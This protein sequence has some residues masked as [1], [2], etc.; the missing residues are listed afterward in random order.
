MKTEQE[1][2]ALVREAIARHGR[3]AQ[4]PHH[5]LISCLREV[6]VPLADGHEPIRRLQAN[7]LIGDGGKPRDSGSRSDRKS[8]DSRHTR[9][10]P[11]ASRTLP[12]R[13]SSCSTNG[14]A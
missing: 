13:N 5:L 11:P 6:A 12:A 4:E 2:R 8:D 10:N 14:H 9:A 7:N 1:L 3:A